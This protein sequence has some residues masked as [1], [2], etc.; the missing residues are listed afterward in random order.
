MTNPTTP[1]SWQMP[2]STDL[3]TDLPAD[4]ETFGQA[5][6]TSMADLLGGTTGQVLSKAS[7]TDMDFTW[8]A[9]DDSNAIQNSIVDAKGDLIAASANDTP[10]RLAV[11]NNGETIVA[12]SSQTTGLAWAGN[13][14]AGKNKIING[15]FDVWQRGSSFTLSSNTRTYCADRFAVTSVFSAGSSSVSRQTFTPATAPVAGYEGQYFQRITAATTSTYIDCFQFIEDVRTFAGQSVTFSFWAKA[16]ASVTVNGYRIQNFGSGGSSEVAGV[17]GT[18]GLT[19]SWQR[20]TTTFTVPSISG[21]TVGTSSFLGIGFYI[22]SG[23][24][25]GL[26]IDT[27]GVQLEAGSV[28]TAFQTATGTLQGETSACQRYY[29]LHASGIHLSLGN[30]GYYS[31]TQVNGIVQLPTTMRTVPTL[32]ASSGTSFYVADRNGGDDPFNSL[33]IYRPS[34]T[35]AMIYNNSEAT[36]TAGHAALLYTNNASSSVAFS[37]E[38]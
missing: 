21:K 11:G 7:N 16:S 5:V 25:A 29:Y 38:L 10:A 32:V 22:S 8:V 26:T 4:F 1:F 6:A 2:T 20:F 19:T 3:V 37:A 18:F 31:A 23:I 12:D 15:A 27:W 13:Y 28:A 36:G 17:Q 9:Q 30:A 24:T 35:A 34:T 14:A 33:T